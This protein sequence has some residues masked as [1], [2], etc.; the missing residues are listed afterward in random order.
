MQ[1]SAA[2][3]G[4]EEE[5]D[6]GLTVLDIVKHAVNTTIET[7]AEGDRLGVVSYSDEARTALTL[8]KMDETGKDAARTCLDTLRPDGQTNLWDG[9]LKALDLLRES[10]TGRLQSIVLLTDGHLSPAGASGDAAE[11]QGA[12]PW[13]CMYHLHVRLW[14]QPGLRQAATALSRS[15]SQL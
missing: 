3:Q 9:L 10:S 4:D 1:A 15:Q 13:L 2:V 12:A 11:V 14:V 8:T 5:E 6:D 7:L